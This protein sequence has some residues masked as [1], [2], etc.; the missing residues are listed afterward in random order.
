MT[1]TRASRRFSARPWCRSKGVSMPMPLWQCSRLYH[2][3]KARQWVRASSIDPKRSGKSGRYFIVL[4][5]ASE[6]GLSSETL[7][8]EWLLVTPRSAKSKAS[9]FDVIDVLGDHPKP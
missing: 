2:S 9:D 8:R 1:A 4:N 6:N 7:G 3:K 5:W